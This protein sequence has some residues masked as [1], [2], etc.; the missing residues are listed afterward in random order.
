MEVP[1]EIKAMAIAALTLYAIGHASAWIML[2][3]S[4]RAE[5]PAE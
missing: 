4:R 2:F 5:E 1:R 3:R